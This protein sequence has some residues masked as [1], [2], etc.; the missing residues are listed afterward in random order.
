MTLFLENSFSVNNYISISTRI[1]QIPLYFIYFIPIDR[2]KN[3]DERYKI[4]PDTKSN[5]VTREIKHKILYFDLNKHIDFYENVDFRKSSYFEKSLYHI[6]YSCSVLRDNHISFTPTQFPFV[7]ISDN[8][9]NNKHNNNNDHNIMCN[10]FDSLPLLNNFSHS[11]YFPS[12]HLHNLKLY[13]S[14]SLL[15]NPYIPI[16][17]F[18]IT[19]L[20]HYPIE[21][22]CNDNIEHIL[23]LFLN[24]R[25]KLDKNTIKQNIN[26]L[27]NY[28]SK[29]IIPYLLQFKNTW[30][31]YSICSFFMVNYP[32]LLNNFSLQKLFHSYIHAS[33]KERSSIL[34]EELHDI[35]FANK[36]KRSSH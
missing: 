5:T 17:I 21:C 36:Q 9:H 8:I 1:K 23:D 25:E 28:K 16:D 22:L 15:Q 34:L 4:L 2:F 27:C 29:Q 10:K 3:L 31:D 19:Y 32:D 30:S 26:Y 6:F 33:F 7:L 13:F 11:F 24:D 18:L 35:L 14:Q 20:T 12:I